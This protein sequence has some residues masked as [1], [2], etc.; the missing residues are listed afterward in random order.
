MDSELRAR[1]MQLVEVNPS[2]NCW[3]HR[4]ARKDPARNRYGSIRIN[5]KDRVI[6]RVSYEEYVGPIPDGMEIDHL[7]WV[8]ACC[9]PEHLE[10]VT[11]AENA[12]RNRRAVR[13]RQEAEERRAAR[14]NSQRVT[15]DNTTSREEDERRRAERAEYA[16]TYRERYIKPRQEARK[17]ARAAYLERVEK[18]R[19]ENTKRIAEQIAA[20]YPHLA[21]VAR[22]YHS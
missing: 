3:E 6:H 19:K 8:R 18:E 10:A 15:Y 4:A 5:G 9:N 13:Y 20:K 12:R 16:K 22:E 2:T 1:I 7:C 11:H 17:A 14:N 21:R